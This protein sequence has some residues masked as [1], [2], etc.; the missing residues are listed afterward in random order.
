MFATVARTLG[1]RV[2][3]Q[4]QLRTLLLAAFCTE[5]GVAMAFPLRL[6]YAQA[7]GATPA[8]LGLF[9]SVY[10]LA[11]VLV[12]LPVGWLVDR[13][14]RVPVLAVS[15]AG[16]ALIGLAYI[17]FTAPAELIGLRFFEG[18]VLAGVQPAAAAYIADVTVEGQRAEAYGV[19]S[20]TLSGGLLLGPLVGGV[21]G[22]TWG[23]GA[24]YAL[25]AAV[26]AVAVAL[27]VARVR[28]PQR[29]RCGPAEERA[30]PWRRLLAPPL[31]G[32]YAAIGATQIIMGLFSALWTI[33]L[34]DLGGSYTYIGVI[35]TVFALPGLLL[36]ALGGRAA[37]RWGLA[38]TLLS[39]GLAIGLIYA[40]YGFVTN[41]T[42]LPF[43]CA[44][45]AVLLAFQA[46][47]LQALLAAASPAEARGRAQGIAG[48][49]GALG[50]GSAAL[51]S[52]ALYHWSQ[53]APF[54]L[55]GVVM[56]AGALAAA[57]GALR[58]TRC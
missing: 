1:G 46:P 50:G 37:D 17:V 55:S 29:P 2:M 8:E 41:L 26:E 39:F 24:A 38:P 30:L 22:Q 9:A 58:L 28:E 14:G 51:V 5:L 32:A 52:L 40:G 42:V 12:Q 49:V 53:P 36:G 11:P 25:S 43:L 47:A 13:W 16:H 10:V 19:L 21:A 3:R 27:L 48:L 45:E 56:A 44:L 23:F 33:R 34:H 54:V 18:A 15:L 6:L 35:Y 7:H 31:L 57:L 4:Q 20:A